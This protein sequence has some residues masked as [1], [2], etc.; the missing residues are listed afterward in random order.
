MSLTR[1][2]DTKPR[3]CWRCATAD[4]VCGPA[5]LQMLVKKQVHLESQQHKLAQWA[6]ELQR[7]EMELQVGNGHC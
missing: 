2:K 3:G 7:R 1:A 6:M 5:R 4:H